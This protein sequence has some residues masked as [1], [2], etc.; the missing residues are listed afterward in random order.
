[1]RRTITALATIM[2]AAGLAN[3][4][5]EARTITV[6]TILNANDVSTQAMDEW[7][8]LLEERTE[9]RL[10]LNILPG[11]TLGGTRELVQQLSSGE[12]DVNVSSPVV[13]QF[14]APQYQCLEGEY[15]F[16]NEQHGLD[17]WRGK[18]GEEAS[19]ALQENY[20]IEIAAVGRRGSRNVT[21][22][23]PVRDPSDMAGLKMRVTNDLRTEV[24]SKFG[25]QPAPLPLSELYGALRQGVFDAQENPLSTIFSLRFHEVQD[26]ISLT[27]HI[28]TYT[29][30][31]VNS[32]FHESLGDDRE[33]FDQTLNEA[34]DWLST[35]VD[36][37]TERV[38]K[39]IKDSGDAEI[40]EPDVAAFREQAR[41][42]VEA[43]AEAN[44]K[45]GLLAEV[46]A[47]AGGSE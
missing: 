34:M 42:V 19:Q 25:A 26:Y 8:R 43:Y 17:V 23:K 28:W 14:A 31:Y 47:A 38:T 12:I 29:I 9:G 5:A 30:V 22:N 18:V 24:F 7:N 36:E 15:V 3:M 41:P 37:E 13:L 1:M 10:S 44:C 35:K 45:P 11:G 21:A 33:V 46:D 16:E 27:E 32:D 4:A 39:A 2:A 20:A 40:I 6:A